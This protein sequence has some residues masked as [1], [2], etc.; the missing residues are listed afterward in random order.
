MIPPPPPIY[1]ANGGAGPNVTPETE[2]T[3]VTAEEK[4]AEPGCRPLD[5]SPN[6][7]SI[8]FVVT[9][10][11]L[12]GNALRPDYLRA[13]LAPVLAE[14][15]I[16]AWRTLE[17]DETTAER[18]RTWSIYTTTFSSAVPRSGHRALGARMIG[19]RPFSTTGPS[20][21][22]YPGPS[23]TSLKRTSARCWTSYSAQP[24]NPQGGAL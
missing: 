16:T 17:H 12:S 6:A 18:P 8:G 2:K 22:P 11:F 23:S 10:L 24:T 15:T 20:M 21:S 3:S 14:R 9:R 1:G 4:A 13:A 5:P 19:D 7:R